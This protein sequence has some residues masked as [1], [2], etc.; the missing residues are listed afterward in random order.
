MSVVAVRE[1][2]PATSEHAVHRACDSNG[3]SLHAACEPR[4]VPRLDDEVKVVA[5]DVFS[6]ST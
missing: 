3:E 1:Y 4:R 6:K 2:L 5:L